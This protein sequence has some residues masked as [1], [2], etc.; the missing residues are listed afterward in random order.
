M[1]RIC[2]CDD[3]KEQCTKLHKQIDKYTICK[4]INVSTVEY[5][6]PDELFEHIFDFDVLF[7]DVLFGDKK[8]GYQVGLKLRTLG[9]KAEIIFLTSYDDYVYKGYEINAFR[10]LFKSS[11][12]EEEIFKVLDALISEKFSSLSSQR[13]LFKSNFDTIVVDIDKI[14]YITANKKQ[15]TVVMTDGTEYITN[16]Y[17]KDLYT[18]LPETQFVYPQQSFIVNLRYIH[19]KNGKMIVLKNDQGVAIEVLFG[20]KYKENFWKKFNDYVDSK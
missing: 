16:E 1:I 7:L 12:D 18:K 11:T 3:D 2:I 17:L 13:L 20:R 10:Y 19:L 6:D 5:Y 8:V 14:I 9:C 4:D 15:R